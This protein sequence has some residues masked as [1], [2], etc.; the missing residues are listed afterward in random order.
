MPRRS[1][2]AE[3][4]TEVQSEVAVD[5][6]SVDT[7]VGEGDFADDIHTDFDVGEGGFGG[8]IGDE[9]EDIVPVATD[10]AG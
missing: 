5:N 9:F 1:D 8:G 4:S 2:F 3:F 10:G 7:V 6:V